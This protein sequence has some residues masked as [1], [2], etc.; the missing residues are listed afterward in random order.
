VKGLRARGGYRVDLEWKAGELV[1]CEIAGPKD[2]K[3]KVNYGGKTIDV[4]RDSR[5]VITGN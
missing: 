2:A 5:F 3:P 1:R 4:S